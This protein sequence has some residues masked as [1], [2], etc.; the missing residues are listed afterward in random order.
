MNNREYL[1]TVSLPLD[2]A[3]LSEGL[4]GF[5]RA[6]A[7]GIV[8]HPPDMALVERWNPALMRCYE[9]NIKRGMAKAEAIIRALDETWTSSTTSGVV[10]QL[11]VDS[12]LTVKDALNALFIDHVMVYGSGVRPVGVLGDGRP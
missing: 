4:S 3:A 10:K 1:T 12:S 8:G 9:A 6:M 2:L 7:A 5:P 11:L